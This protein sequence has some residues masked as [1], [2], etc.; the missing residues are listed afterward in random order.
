MRFRYSSQE[1]KSLDAIGAGR[2]LGSITVDRYAVAG[3]STV[4]S[5]PA[6]VSSFAGDSRSF[7]PCS[8]TLSASSCASL[9]FSI[10][11]SVFRDERHAAARRFRPITGLHLERP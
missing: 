1:D 9:A 4:N 3:C 5:A 6:A 2:Y 8:L 10:A 11:C 7:L